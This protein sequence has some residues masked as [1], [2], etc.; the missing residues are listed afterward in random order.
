MP[1]V[2]LEETS[3]RDGLQ[4]EKKVLST[5]EKRTL[6]LLLM[7][8]GI[9]RI[10]IG[11]FVNPARVPQMAGVEELVAS[12]PHGSDVLFTALVLNDRGRERAMACG[13]K[14]LS[15][16]VSVSDTH[17]RKNAN[18]PADRAL[19]EMADLI[20]RTVADGATVRGGIQ[21][22]FGCV[23]EGAVDEAKVLAAAETL[24]HAGAAEINLSDTT[25]MGEP[26]QVKRL[27]SGVRTLLPDVT[28]SLHLHDTRGL[29]LAN[30]AAGLEEGVTLFDTSA[31][32]LGGCPFVP[33]AS[34]NVATEAAVAMLERKGFSTGVNLGELGKAVEYLG[35]LLGRSLPDPACPSPAR[36]F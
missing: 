25:G 1:F 13:L 7:A 36:S 11:S 23:Y 33:G 15:M 17:S 27:V 3:L 29:G 34:G 32:G 30:M 26:E 22:A 12:L 21:C 16:S 35:R 10:Q 14:H 5:A 19:A 18:R 9:E 20:A 8:A 4:F 31:G 2:M 28:L 6:L 24:A